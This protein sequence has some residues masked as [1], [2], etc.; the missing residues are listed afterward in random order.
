MQ[1]QHS[2]RNKRRRILP[3]TDLR[4]LITG[5]GQGRT[6]PP[7]ATPATTPSADAPPL[8]LPHRRDSQPEES[9]GPSLGPS[10]QSGD[11]EGRGAPQRIPSAGGSIGTP[12][13]VM[14]QHGNGGA[15]LAH[16][17]QVHTMKKEEKADAVGKPEAQKIAQAST[18]VA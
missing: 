6:K 15:A 13:S 12:A 5:T 3:A 7:S 18:A 10:A 1:W 17:E 8:R 16:T 9:M 4:A 14:R 11:K 2:D